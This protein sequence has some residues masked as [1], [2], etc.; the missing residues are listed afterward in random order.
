MQT[1][2]QIANNSTV[3][4]KWFQRWWGILIITIV[5]IIIIFLVYFLTL[6]YNEY[7]NISNG[8]GTPSNSFEDFINSKEKISQTSP[9][10]NYNDD[11][12]LGS[13]QAKVKIIE[14]GDF[15]CPFCK[16]EFLVIRKIAID[17]G[18]Q[19]QIIF[20]DFPLTSIHPLAQK[21]AEAAGCA[22]AQDQFW[23][24][25]D[26]I[27]LN[28]ENLSEDNFLMFAN[29]LNLN[30][31]QFQTCLN[32]G[33]REAEV[34]NDY[35]DGQALGISGTPSLII[36]NTLIEGGLTEQQ[37]QI[38]IEYFLTSQTESDSETGLNNNN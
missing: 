34:K 4:K 17:Y 23:P 19:V 16:E 27:F 36:N 30:L 18:D 7:Q 29:E 37:F 13:P 5:T 22:Q 25:H 21:A 15:Q 1:D 3:D 24:Y 11:P 38:L 9:Y 32:S 28:Q 33:S 10:L 20:R 12:Y 2:N 31:A 6:V 26:K 35:Q 8:L 14:F